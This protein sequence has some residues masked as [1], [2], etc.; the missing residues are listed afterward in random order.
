[1]RHVNINPVFFK[2][3]HSKSSPPSEALSVWI[4]FFNLQKFC[5]V[6]QMFFSEQ[7]RSS[8]TVLFRTTS[9]VS[10]CSSQNNCFKHFIQLFFSE[11]L[12]RV[13]VWNYT[14]SCSFFSPRFKVSLFSFG[15]SPIYLYFTCIFAP[16]LKHQRLFCSLVFALVQL[17]DRNCAALVLFVFNVSI[18]R[19]L[20]ISF[21]KSPFFL[22]ISETVT[23]F[24]GFFPPHFRN[25]HD[26]GF[27][28][29]FSLHF[30]RFPYFWQVF[31]PVKLSILLLL[32][33]DFFFK[34]NDFHSCLRF[35]TLA[36]LAARDLQLC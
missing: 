32:L 22:T 34:V 1:M 17:S 13:V 21:I 23:V 29:L 33:L 19:L 7:H 3:R 14:V 10:N 9:L 24:G 26:F 27:A 28:L 18:S 8:T 31:R 20:H 35:C 12:S 25:S 16:F 5:P 15:I 4:P 36:S 6:F 2:F 11:Q 30:N